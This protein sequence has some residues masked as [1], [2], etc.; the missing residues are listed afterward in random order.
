MGNRLSKEQEQ[1]FWLIQLLFKVAGCLPDKGSLD[2]EIW[3]KVGWRTPH[4][5]QSL[6]K[7]RRGQCVPARPFLQFA[8]AA[9]SNT[10]WPVSSAG[11]R[12]VRAHS[13]AVAP[14][15]ARSQCV[16]A[17]FFCQGQAGVEEVLVPLPSFYRTQHRAWSDQPSPGLRFQA[18]PSLSGYLA[19][20]LELAQTARLEGEFQ[21]G[22]PEV[23]VS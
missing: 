4:N 19:A 12:Y 23:F 1:S 18:A 21:P 3:E 14:M 16:G 6:N 8:P 5:Q 15:C 7:K 2:L 13:T 22:L 10:A 9:A 17:R 11:C 20:D